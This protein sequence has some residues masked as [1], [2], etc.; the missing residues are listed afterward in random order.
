MSSTVTDPYAALSAGTASA[1]GSSVASPASGSTAAGSAD[2]FLK[3]LVT[4]MKNQDPLN[5]MD[6]AQITSQIA[7]INTVS[8]IQQLNTTVS[9]LNGQFVQ[10]QALQGASLVG[11]DIT[12]KGSRLDIAGGS[13]VG[14]FDLAG[15]ADN[16]NVQIVSPAGQVVDTVALGALGSGRHGF[17]W[18]AAGVADGAAYTFKVVATSGAAAVG[19]TPLML[20]RVTAATGGGSGLTLSTAHSGDIAYGNVIAFN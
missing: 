15:T 1:A 4:Q 14:G 18:P 13:G 12:L 9:G 19:A 3:L 16:V 17:T 5:P 10:M 20:D 6:N 7:Q 2:A 11:H 8:G